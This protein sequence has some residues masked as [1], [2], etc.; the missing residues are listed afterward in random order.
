RP[1]ILVL[2][3][4]NKVLILSASG[5]LFAFNLSI[6]YTAARTLAYKYD[7]DALDTG[8]VLLAY[9][10]G[11][12]CLLGSIIGGRYSD[13]T[14]AK[15]TAE[16]GANIQPDMRLRSTQLSMFFFSPSVI[17]YGWVCEKHVH[18]SAICAM[19]FL[20]GFFQICIYTSTLAY[21][22]DANVGRSASAAALNSFF[23]GMFALVATEV[24][25]PLQES[26]GDGG[27]YILWRRLTL[28]SDFLI[29]LVW[30][31]GGQMREK[32]IARET[33]QD[34]QT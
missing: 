5:L 11:A 32:A 23:R 3:R 6:T 10:V 20:A 21:I 7:Y 8:L 30:W 26:I 18:V 14:F 17:G 2:N 27:L 4:V 13:Y 16:Y 33:R 31:K 29:L 25:V 12:C 34:E 15:L 1:M 22:V 19:L 9:G 28:V 24:A